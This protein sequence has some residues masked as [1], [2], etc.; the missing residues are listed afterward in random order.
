[1]GCDKNESIDMIF[2]MVKDQDPHK[3]GSLKKTKLW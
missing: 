2:T 3:P 1:M